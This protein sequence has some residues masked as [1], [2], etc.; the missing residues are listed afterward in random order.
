M[1]W[2]TM[3]LIYLGVLAIVLI[4]RYRA[5]KNKPPCEKW[6]DDEEM[7]AISAA[8]IER[9]NRQ[10]TIGQVVLIFAVL[11]VLVAS[12]G[13][14]AGDLWKLAKELIRLLATWMY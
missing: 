11:L 8:K 13:Y 6:E 10:L 5:G 12:L 3:A 14:F 2:I 7:A 4:S 9:E 1:S